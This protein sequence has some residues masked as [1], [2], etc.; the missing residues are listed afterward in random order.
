MQPRKTSV[1]KSVSWRLIGAVML[2][3]VTYV[4]TESLVITTL[5]TLIHHSFYATVYYFHERAWLR[6][7]RRTLLKYKR[8]IKGLTY[9]FG[10]GYLGTQFIAY[11]VS[12]SWSDA[13]MITLIYLP[14]RMLIFPFHEWGWERAPERVR[15]R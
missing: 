7:R 1:L 15:G 10:L 5:N 14:C 9:E 8:I 11:F 3:V 12:G 4:I 13:T 6:A 2:A